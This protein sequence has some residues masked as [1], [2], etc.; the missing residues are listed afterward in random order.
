MLWQPAPTQISLTDNTV[1]IWMLDTRDYSDKLDYLFQI[2]SLA[3]QDRA[4][5]F[6]FKVHRDRFIVNRANLKIILSKYFNLK[7]EKIEFEYGDKGKPR[8]EKSLN[9]IQLKFSVSHTDDLVIYAVAQHNIGIDIESL[10]HQVDCEQ[11]AERFF[12]C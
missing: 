6:K 2:L 4:N 12:L 1:H 11:M 10:K 3:E 8:V 9:K 5:R 7:P